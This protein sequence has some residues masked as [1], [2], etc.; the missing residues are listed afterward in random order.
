MNIVTL[1]VFH[2]R[3]EKQI[4]IEFEYNSTLVNALKTAGAKWS[5]TVSSWYIGYSK[6]S[7]DFLIQLF[8]NEF[9]FEL[10]IIGDQKIKEVLPDNEKL[11]N[12]SKTIESSQTGIKDPKIEEDYIKPHVTA[13][14]QFLEANRYSNNTVR[15]YCDGLKIF[16]S[17]TY[18]KPVE[19]I[20]NQDLEIFFH[21]HSFK[22]NLS[23]SWQRLII[24]ALKLFFAQIHNKK[25]DIHLMLRPK[26][27]KL[28]P[29]VLS[30]EE[31][32]Q[33]LNALTNQKHKLM[34]V[35]IYTCGLRRSELLNLKPQHVDSDRKVLIIKQAKG[36]KDRLTQ[37]PQKVIDQ[38][39]NYYAKAKPR[40]WL[41][42]GQKPGEQYSERSL[43]LVFK[44]ALAKTSIKKPATLHWLRHSYATHLLE[45][46]VNIRAI[47]ELLGHSS[48]KTTEIYT[49]VTSTTIQ[50][51]PSP[52]EDLDI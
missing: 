30:K 2:H 45:K 26:K 32:Q 47:Q 20:T 33:I 10:K 39:R 9:E 21:Q 42:E 25:V 36:R 49:H 37:L 48:L 51:I 19:E 12:V 6:P 5:K 17:K 27:D 40:T 43:N 11:S 16:L 4:K 13:F 18:P 7:Y 24:N 28:L 50:S 38:L 1:S 22:N 34:L 31:V 3:G 44:Q 14:K 29:N 41:F 52:I 23:I 15:S 8:V 35:L 46:G